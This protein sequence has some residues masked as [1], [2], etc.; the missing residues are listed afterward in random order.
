MAS[1]IDVFK[2]F[3][4]DFTKL[5]PMIIN[6]LVARF[7]SDGYLSGDHKSRI[8]SLPTDEEKTGYFLDRVIKPGLETKFTEQF[9][10][11]L[12]VMKT[13]DDCAI[14]NLVEEVQKFYPVSMALT[15]RVTLGRLG[16][17]GSLPK[18]MSIL[19]VTIPVAKVNVG[20]SGQTFAYP[21]KTAFYLCEYITGAY[22]KNC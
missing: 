5:L 13:S 10:E 21:L 7:Y 4:S 14:G 9:D 20:V 22:F 15:P 11:M 3:Y 12:R 18:G 2:K 8:D 16:G 6:K 17:G 19:H 1:A